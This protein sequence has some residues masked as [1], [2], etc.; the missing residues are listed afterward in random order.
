MSPSSVLII[1][2]HR[3]LGHELAKLYGKSLTSNGDVFVT[4]EQ[5]VD[6]SESCSM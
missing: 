6:T 2:A 3:G 5:P 1:G 4:V